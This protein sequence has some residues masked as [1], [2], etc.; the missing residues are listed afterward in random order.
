MDFRYILKNYHVMK[1]TILVKITL[2][3]IFKFK[4]NFVKMKLKQFYFLSF[5]NLFKWDLVNQF[6][7]TAWFIHTQDQREDRPNQ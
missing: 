3:I 5:L 1:I 6:I 2:V 7:I 4:T